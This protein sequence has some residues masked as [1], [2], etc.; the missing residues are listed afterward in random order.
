[1]K[2]KEK[3]SWGLFA[4]YKDLESDSECGRWWWRLT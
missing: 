3:L 4:I 2:V 1:M